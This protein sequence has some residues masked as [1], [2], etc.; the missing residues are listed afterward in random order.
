MAVIIDSLVLEITRR[1]NMS[2]S[3][4]LRGDA[5]NVDMDIKYVD[6]LFSKIDQIYTL[7]FTGGE[8]SLVPDIIHQVL[9]SANRNDVEITN[10]YLVT[11]GKK[12]TM[13]FIQVL[14]RIY[15]EYHNFYN[16]ED[17]PIIQW[18]ND[19]Y[20]DEDEIDK[21][22]LRLLKA[23]KFA[24]PRNKKNDATYSLIYQGRA[25]D[26]FAYNRDVEPEKFEIEEEEYGIIIREG[27]LYLNC[28]GYLISGCDFSYDNQ[29]NE[30]H[31]SRICP[32]DKF[33]IEKI[34]EYQE[35]EVCV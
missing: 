18:S 14:L 27:T 13:E 16:E 22:G 2:C 1:C 28:N 34:K 11:N 10:F 8:P 12:I 31:L 35:S 17:M 6:T 15:Q 33:S 29:D 30:D 5:E 9:D 25:E 23:L 20:H 24:S 3:H 32:V 21:E 4:C 7:T 26:N 19:I